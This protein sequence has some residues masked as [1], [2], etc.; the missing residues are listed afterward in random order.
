M[1]YLA[2]VLLIYIDD[3]VKAFWCLFYILF[4][5]NW[6]KVYDDNTPKL[7]NLL[8]LVKNKLLKTDIKL[9]NHLER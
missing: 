3:E 1:N 6:R 5:K 8:D 9:F 7:M 2:A 4:R